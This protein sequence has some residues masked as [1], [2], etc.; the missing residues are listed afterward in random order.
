M[1]TLRKEMLAHNEHE[2]H[3][4]FHKEQVASLLENFATNEIVILAD[5]IQNIA[6]SRGRETSQ[7]YY[8]KR[9]TQFLSFVIY[10][11]HKVNGEVKTEKKFVDYLFSYLKHNSLFFSKC[12]THL[13]TYLWDELK[14]EFDKIGSNKVVYHFNIF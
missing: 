8:S 7:S 2:R 10:R 6:H 12:I 14:W 9:Q 11:K 1:D 4:I 5:F 3:V 13:L